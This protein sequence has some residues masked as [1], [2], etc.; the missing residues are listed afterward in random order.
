MGATPFETYDNNILEYS[1]ELDGTGFKHKDDNNKEVSGC[2]PIVSGAKTTVTYSG[3]SEDLILS[4]YGVTFRRKIYEPGRIQAELLIQTKEDLVIGTLSSML[5]RR[6]VSL[7][8]TRNNGKRKTVATNY[9]ILDISPQFENG[10]DNTYNYI[11]IKLDIVSKDAILKFNRFSQAH[12]GE[13]FFSDTVKNFT[14]AAG[15]PLRAFDKSSF[16]GLTY[17]DNNKDVEF[18][19]P[20]F[21]QYNESFYAFMRRLSNRCGEAFYFEDGAL[22]FGLP[23]N[24]NTTNI[25]NALRVIYQRVSDGPYSCDGISVSDY[26]RDS[27]KEYRNIG[28]DND[29][30]EKWTYEPDTNKVITDKIDVNTDTKCPKEVFPK[31]DFIN[32][33]EIASEDHYMILFKDKFA[34]DSSD[35]LWLGDPAARPTLAVSAFLNSTSL[36]EAMGNLVEQQIDAAYALIAKKDKITNAGNE[37]IEEERID[38]R[39]TYAVLYSKVDN[40]KSHWITLDYYT[41]I[42]DKEEA[43]A[44]KMVCVDMGE[45]YCD[46]KLGDKITIP[47][48]NDSIYIVTDIEMTSGVPWKRRYD[49]FSGDAVPSGGTQSQRLYAIP[50]A[51]NFKFYP[52]LLTDKPFLSA[53]PQPAYVVEINDPYHQG[54]VRVRY[55]WQPSTADEKSAVDKAKGEMGSKEIA[56][57]EYAT[58]VE[59]DDRSIKITKIEGKDENKFNTARTE[60]LEKRS[61]WLKALYK[62]TIKEAASPWIRM[63]TPMA[64]NGGG[65]FFR[66]EVGDEVMVDY[67]NGNIDR[68][69]VTGALYSKNV[70]APMRGDHAIVSKNGHT[71]KLD[72]PD[73]TSLIV[74]GIFPFIKMLG[75]FGVE[76]K[77]IKGQSLAAL[78]G[79]ELTDKAGIYDIKMSSHDRRIK[80]SSP[81]GDVKIDA[82]TGITLNAPN[83]DINITGKNINLS[84]YN[85]VNVTS[86]RNLLLGS[87]DHLGGW[88]TAF[89]GTGTGF[90]V[91]KSILNESALKF[92]DFTLLRTVLE[93]FVRPIDGSMAFKSYR[94]MQLEAGDGSVADEPENYA[95]RPLDEYNKAPNAQI[96]IDVINE[97]SDRIDAFISGYLTTFNKVRK[98]VDLKFPSLDYFGGGKTIEVPAQKDTFLKDIFQNAPAQN[99]HNSCVMALTPYWSNV[100]SFKINDQ[101]ADQVKTTVY[102]NVVELTSAVVD[103]KKKAADF[104]HILDNLGAPYNIFNLNVTAPSILKMAQAI[105]GGAAVPNGA[106]ANQHEFFTDNVNK[107]L[108]FHTNPD[109]NLFGAADLTAADFAHWKR[110]IMRRL[111]YAVIE[112]CRNH[113]G[114]IDGCTFP[115]AVYGPVRTINELGIPTNTD[116]SLSHDIFDDLDWPNYVGAIRVDAPA[117]DEHCNFVKGMSDAFSFDFYKKF[118]MLE[119]WVWKPSSAG[120]ILFSDEEK[121]TV[122]FKNG[123]TESYKNPDRKYGAITNAIKEKLKEL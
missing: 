99:D 110:C 65:M 12:L 107:V 20:Y 89:G 77:G 123:A 25:E 70:P 51:S 19:Q 108:N 11:Y 60:Y 114:L 86:G 14:A 48:D 7:H 18:I 59:N 55:P 109:A 120:K 30:N 40:D 42:R 96:V 57:K 8:V 5:I 62:L 35:D 105:V 121:T 102:G 73:D 64:T 3:I 52:P 100:Q 82:L 41:D 43:Q 4:L 16:Q 49:D 69:F 74:Q 112:E 50:L 118:M 56:L 46:I 94:Y 26:A 44:R 84:A 117:A 72:D 97:I 28:K 6:S 66:P 85:R 115:A 90:Q 27:L 23:K 111:A 2:P 83:G 63:S 22:C 116:T 45:R 54:R 122:R 33:S 106:S 38:K 78:G 80:I 68:P 37:L 104:E 87:K 67:E 47:G 98:V 88:I 91:A 15:V 32:N 76:F 113:A 29:G 103:L 17:K 13:K 10:T 31:G 34:H 39:N 95:R 61:D 93:I 71:I 101:A 1:L 24:G 79:I 119:W 9:F 92:F 21:V 53:G 81:L 58:I 36:L 75:T